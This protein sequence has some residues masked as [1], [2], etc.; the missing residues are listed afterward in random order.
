MADIER[1]QKTCYKLELTEQEYHAILV[2]VGGLGKIEYNND[3]AVKDGR[4]LPHA[5]IGDFYEKL[6]KSL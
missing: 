5:Q 2:C 3:V 4:A 1:V 6:E